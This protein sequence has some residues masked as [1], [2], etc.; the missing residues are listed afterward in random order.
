MS[1]SIQDAKSEL[2]AM[3]HG[4][5]LAQVVNVDGVFNRAA[6][7]LMLDVDPQE[8]KRILPMDSPIYYQIFDYSIPEDIKGNKVIDLI[9]LQQSYKRDI[10]YSTYNQNFDVYKKSSP[11]NEL[12]II[13]NT[14]Y[15]YMRVNY[16]NKSLTKVLD[17][18]SGVNNNGLWVASGT[19]SNLMVNNQV[20]NSNIP[21]VSFDATTGTATLTNATL[22]AQDLSGHFDQGSTFFTFYLP[23]SSLITSVA[24]KI[25][26]S[27][28]DYYVSSPLTKQFNNFDIKDGYNQFGVIFANMTKVGNPDLTKINYFQ[29][30]A[31]F[32]ANAYGV[33]FCQI[34]NSLGFLFDIEYYSKYL[35]RNNIT[36][37]WQEKVLSDSDLIN[38]DTESYNLFLYQAAF[39]CVQQALGQDAG[40]DTNIF[41]DKYNQALIRYKKMYKSELQKVQQPYYQ[42]PRRGYN[43]ILGSGNNN[44]Y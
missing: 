34:Q 28:T 4:T 19:A 8:T 23:D 27:S 33:A 10:I 9:P 39:L 18:V 15:K 6:R 3:L 25:G 29:I 30:N 5:T 40:Y 20:T 44:P 16:N 12:S 37:V 43:G 21:T 13:S 2:E 41:L 42:L 11:T 17:Q 24:I 7:Q 38:L 14:G 35:F 26:S 32:N 1:F 22:G 36:G 31:I